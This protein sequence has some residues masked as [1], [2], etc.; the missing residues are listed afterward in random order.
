M[1][2][3]YL[4]DEPIEFE[5]GETI[6]KAALR[7][8]KD[9]PRYCYHP[10]LTV[11]AQCRMCL[12][13]VTDMG[14]GRPA[15]KLF[16]SC[17]TPAMPGMKVS[18]QTDKVKE[19]QN[20]ISEL[21][22]VNHP[23]DCPICDQSGECDL[24]DYAFQYG[25]G[26]SE[27]THEK[28]TY[29]W[30]DVGT[31]IMLE[32]NRCIH[33]SRCERYSKEVEGAHDF[34]VFLR[35][36]ETTFDT[37]EDHR[38]THKFQGNLVDLCP[39]G[40]IT[41]REFRF[42]KRAWKLT[43][44]PSVCASCATG[45]NITVDHES[46][47][48]ERLKPRE[49]QAVNRWWMCDDG[50]IG[51]RQLNDREHRAL[52]PQARVKGELIPANWE[53]IQLAVITRL[54]EISARGDQVVGLAD[55]TATNEELFLFKKMLVDCFGA[56]TYSPAHPQQAAPTG[57]FLNDL[58]SPD[59]TPNS[60]GAKA[61]GLGMDLK[62]DGVRKALEKSPKVVFVLGNP[63]SENSQLLA[64]AAKADFV[65]HIATFSSP[66]VQITDVVLPGATFAEKAGTYTNKH[67]RVQRIFPAVNPPE[68][69]RDQTRIL[70]DLMRGLGISTEFN[71]PVQVLNGLG[72]QEAAF[73][74]LTWD[75]V[76]TSGQPLAG[77]KA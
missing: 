47:R 25:T 17:S 56:K 46:N 77:I 30:R 70:L 44:T 26:H 32:R 52:E 22:L 64:L 55:T 36:H 42:K 68:D 18:L 60:A 9:V 16:T 6:I 37:F 1:P 2:T 75:T 57:H 12:V 45:C 67:G 66:W 41:E 5:E 43:R 72:S 50:R 24:Q 71:T 27:M 58:I 19:G 15:P 76:G 73:K 28:R 11:V 53:T 33:C 34:G 38:I 69:C 8:G 14:N 61:L 4:D 59:K 74:G 13:D 48:V 23:L 54:E 10:A 51:Y 65:C 7:H 49:N 63:W 39:V 20:I 3:F 21:T 29:G 62:N 35:S 31:Y 40:A